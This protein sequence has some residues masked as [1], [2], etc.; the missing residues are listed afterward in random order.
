MKCQVPSCDKTFRRK[1]DLQRHVESVHRLSTPYV[2]PLCPRQFHRK[3]KAN[4]HCKAVHKSFINTDS[5]KAKSLLAEASDSS[6]PECRNVIPGDTVMDKVSI[7]TDTSN[8]EKCNADLPSQEPEDPMVLDP[9]TA[10]S[11]SV[12]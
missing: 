11:Q 6:S 5:M 10:P 3:D 4:A 9:K 2:C 8:N 12:I 7:A 1:G